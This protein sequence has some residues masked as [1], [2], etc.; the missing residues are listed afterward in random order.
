MTVIKLAADWAGFFRTRIAE[1]GLSA[2]EVD[3]R[4]GLADGYTSKILNGKKLPG[5]FTI[6]RLCRE[7]KIS[8]RP[9]AD[10]ETE[11][12]AL[13]DCDNAHQRGDTLDDQQGDLHVETGT[14]CCPAGAGVAGEA[15]GAGRSGPAAAREPDPQGVGRLHA[16]A[17]ADGS[18]R[19]N[20]VMQRPDVAS[21]KPPVPTRPTV[22]AHRRTLELERDALRASAVALA[23]AATKGDPAA[24]ETLAALPAKL[25]AL[26]FEVDLN[27]EC[28]E[29]A[30]AADAA[31]E[32][33]WRA[34][35]QTLDPEV[36][37]GGI[38]KSECPHLCQPN[39]PG[40]CVLSGGH[41]ST[42]L[43]PTQFGTFHQF[44]I[45]DSGRRI[46]PY[47]KNLQAAKVFDAACDKLKVRGKFA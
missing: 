2:F 32:R 9:I 31:A 26:Q 47:R 13:E 18:S 29:L 8:L 15:A 23:F 28:Q 10:G 38:N 40:G 6:E 24:R 43:H 19:V 17:A 16:A 37:I 42:C 46:F 27:H 25:A 11:N 41:G 20:D 12:C 3:Q 14:S 1:L 30:Q 36:L 21:L 34:A 35:I 33:A 45:D 39:S 4:A 7:L 22:L 44:R 5:A